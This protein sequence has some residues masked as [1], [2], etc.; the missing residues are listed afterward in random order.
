[1][2]P[3]PVIDDAT[4]ERE[5]PKAVAHVPRLPLIGN[6][7]DMLD[8]MGFL[9][10]H[11]PDHG[12]VFAATWLGRRWICLAGPDAIG[13]ALANRDR[14]LA[15][16]PAWSTLIGPFFKRG[17]MLLD[18]DEHLTHRR[19]M[20]EAFVRNRLEGYLDS[21]GPVISRALV[22]W[23]SR[24][25]IRGED[26]VRSIAL[27]IAAQT[28]MGVPVG[29]EADRVNHAFRDC[30]DAGAAVVRFNVPGGR[31]ARGL[32][33]RRY[34][35]DYLRPL[36]EAK[37]N[38]PADDLFSVLAHAVSDEGERFTSDDVIN[39]MIFLLMAAHDTSTSSMSTML[40]YLASEP[41]WQERCRAESL[42]L[43]KTSLTYDD[44]DALP[45]LDL[46]FKEAIRLVTPVPALARY[47]TK[48]TVVGGH[49]VPR[50]S[51]LA[52][53]TCFNH[54]NPDVWPAPDSFD[55]ERF[56]DDRRDDKV[57]RHAYVPFGGGV[58]KCIGM[59]F[60]GMQVKSILH[61]ILL[62]YDFRCVDGYVM[63][64]RWAG[65][66]S[67]SRGV[68]LNVVRRVGSRG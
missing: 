4:S 2:S 36:L 32:S 66:P 21:M 43:G 51:Y 1:M 63:R 17:I 13:D 65:L 5:L 25:R 28:F 7:L 56:A 64:T 9:A 40:Y 15:N 12:E 10:R 45:S 55:P 68:P 60:A 23:P 41:E 46:V 30:V 6:T 62:S 42:A 8:L 34:L 58:H 38:A 33:G 19:I 48:D 67:P 57:H 20:Q 61:Q 50:G 39:H 24:G 26:A 22:D 52:V 14:A 27:D 49:H 59:H 31:W 44:L 3:R 53:A 18:F 11:Y 35:E 54:R 16:G 29:A 37:M 47:A